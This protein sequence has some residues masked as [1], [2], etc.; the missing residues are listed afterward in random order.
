M[1]STLAGAGS[2]PAASPKSVIPVTTYATHGVGSLENCRLQQ[3]G[4]HDGHPAIV[5]SRHGIAA[6]GEPPTHQVLRVYRDEAT[7]EE[8]LHTWVFERKHLDD[9]HLW[10]L[11][12]PG[13]SVAA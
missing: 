4:F 2:L 9:P 1:N 8:V 11:P 12:G 6:N 5:W 3:L 10:A 7:R 13:A